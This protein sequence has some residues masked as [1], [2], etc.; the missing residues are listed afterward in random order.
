MILEVQKEPADIDIKKFRGFMDV[1]GRIYWLIMLVKDEDLSRWN[2]FNRGEQSL[3]H[4]IV[5]LGNIE[6]II[7][8]LENSREISKKKQVLVL[9]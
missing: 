4:D 6:N 5:V 8:K 1:Y 3:C 2:K 9:E 7:N